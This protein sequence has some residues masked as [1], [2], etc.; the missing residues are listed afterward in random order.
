[1]RRW[2][3]ELRWEPG[4]SGVLS[5]DV[6][7][8]VQLRAVV[9]WARANPHVIRYSFRPVDYLEGPRALT[10]SRGHRLEAPDP[11]QPYRLKQDI[12]RYGCRG[13][14]GHDVTACP[15]CGELVVEPVPAHG[16]GAV[17]LGGVLGPD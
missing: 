13:C 9:A 6:E 4:H 2:R 10:C 8:V 5:R 3:Y 15:T 14:P 17:R 11:R 1:M 16:C 7:T 12:R